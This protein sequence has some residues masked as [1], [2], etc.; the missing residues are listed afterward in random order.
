VLNKQIYHGAFPGEVEAGHMLLNKKGQTLES[1]CSGWAVDEKVRSSVLAEPNSLL[2]KEV[3][4]AKKGEAEFLKAAIK[5]DD[6][7]AIGILNETADN[8]AFALSHVVHLFHPEAI[9]IG[10]GLSLI[11]DDLIN[12]IASILPKYI[13]KSFLPGPEIN[14]ASLGK[15]VVPIGAL[16]LAKHSFININTNNS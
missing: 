6:Q 11:G 8:L 2:A 1:L 16:V 9:I 13:L 5:K 7:T 15:L 10:G 12:N 4:N 3:G 14:I